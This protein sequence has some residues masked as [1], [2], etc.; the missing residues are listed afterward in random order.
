MIRNAI[1]GSVV[2]LSFLSSSAFSASSVVVTQENSGKLNIDTNGN[3]GLPSKYQ[4]NR[5]VAGLVWNYS[6]PW[7]PE[8]LIPPPISPRNYG[9]LLKENK[10]PLNFNGYNANLE[11]NTPFTNTSN[12]IVGLYLPEW[13][14]WERG[15]PADFTPVKNVTHV[16]YSFLAICDYQRAN[17]TENNGLLSVDNKYGAAILKAM[18]GRGM[19]PGKTG[20]NYD[21]NEYD[22][23]KWEDQDVGVV[24]DNGGVP[25]EDFTVT[26]YD[27]QASYFMLK[28]MQEMKKANPNVKIMVSVGGW[29]L[30]S[31]FHS[32]VS[33]QTSRDVFVKSIVKF[34]KAN[35]Y[36]DGID[37]D[38]EFPGG[39]GAFPGLA[40]AGYLAEKANYT[41]LVKQLRSA[42]DSNFSGNSRKQIS[43]A[44]SAS[45]AKLAAIDFNSLRNDF[46]FINVMTYD[47]Y[48]AF[49]RYPDH[50]TAVYSKPVAAPFGAPGSNDIVKDET[51]NNIIIGQNPATQAEVLR[52]YS[53]EGAIK[54]IIKNNPQFP[55]QKLVVGAASYSRGW[56][57]IRV[58]KE[59][60]KLF[61][62][63]VASGPDGALGVN[64]TFENG[65]TDF[66]EI[67]DKYMASGNNENLYYDAQAEA[68]YTWQFKSSDGATISANV[69]SFD[70]QRSVIAKA[71]LV[72]DYNLGGLFA[73]D[74]SS[75]NGLILNAMNAGLCNKKGDGSYYNFQEQFAAVVKSVPNADGSVTENILNSPSD[76]LYKFNG[77]NYCARS[78][79]IADVSSR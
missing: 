17:A 76:T 49:S 18:C 33:S 8:N 43:A 24:A 54:Y 39:N 4:G 57:T 59:H 40:K 73:W 15:Y 60:D 7:W 38:W 12:K 42:L 56:H 10:A 68:A 45:P 67:Y 1:I 41:L 25:A 52:N 66:R 53:I 74:A 9:V 70:S 37:L 64:G 16:F 2:S 51:G 69:E 71:K 22:K 63:G 75:D 34:L 20:W 28:S 48:G 61:W 13:A 65:V 5:K 58:K 11:L 23:Y 44:V 72:K 50:Q 21:Q 14:Y 30:S 6:G 79:K 78:N 77:S 62:H 46:D 31:P 19:F 47:L 36:V 29:T 26:K 32:M 27:P 35:S 55:T 3:P